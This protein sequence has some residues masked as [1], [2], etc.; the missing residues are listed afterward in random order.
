MMIEPRKPTSGN[1]EYLGEL[2]PTE[3]MISSARYVSPLGLRIISAV[4]I[5]PAPDGTPRPEYHISMT[6][7]GERVPASLVDTIL[8]HFGAVGW[9]EDNHLSGKARHFWCP[10]GKAP[11]VCPC[12]DDEK[13]THEGDYTWREEPPKKVTP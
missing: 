8:A 11:E 12:K 13:P 3:G 4:E 10:V 1:W 9:D 2:P 6:D 5:V 7:N